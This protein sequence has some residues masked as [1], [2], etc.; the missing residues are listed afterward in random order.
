MSESLEFSEIETSFFGTREDPGPWPATEL[1]S[2]A[3]TLREDERPDG[4]FVFTRYVK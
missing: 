3:I 4:V 2:V 1:W